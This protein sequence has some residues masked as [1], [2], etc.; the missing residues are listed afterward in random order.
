VRIERCWNNTESR[1]VIRRRIEIG[2]HRTVSEAAAKRLGLTGR[3][4]IDE[5]EAPPDPPAW[6]DKVRRRGRQYSTSGSPYDPI[7]HF[8]GQR[9]GSAWHPLRFEIKVQQAWRTRLLPAIRSW[10]AEPAGERPYGL[11][12]YELKWRQAIASRVVIDRQRVSDDRFHSERLRDL[13]KHIHERRRESGAALF[14]DKTKKFCGQFPP[15]EYARA[16]RW[17]EIESIELYR[18]HDK[19]RWYVDAPVDDEQLDYS[20]RACERGVSEVTPSGR[21][22]GVGRDSNIAREAGFEFQEVN[23]TIARRRLKYGKPLRPRRKPGRKPLGTR[24]MTGAERVA[25]HRA[26]KSA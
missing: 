23:N 20:G 19:L 15:P 13:R 6:V 9:W 10:A 26:K 21:P 4:V 8:E 3:L 22:I 12:P 11:R 14:N 18:K 7:N 2:Q 25:K 16:I 5:I 1:V 17:A 24:A